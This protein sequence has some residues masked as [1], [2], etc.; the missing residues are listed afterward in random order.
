MYN[1]SFIALVRLQNQNSSLKPWTLK[2]QSPK[3]YLYHVTRYQT[4]TTMTEW[5]NQQIGAEFV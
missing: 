5:I 4:T 2:I 3:T 1:A